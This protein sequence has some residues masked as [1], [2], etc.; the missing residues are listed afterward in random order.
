MSEE[1]TIAPAQRQRCF[2]D[3]SI[4]GLQS[5]RIVFELHNDIVPRTCENFRALCTGEKG[6]GET[7]KKPLY[8]KVG[9]FN[10]ANLNDDF[11]WFVFRA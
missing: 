10:F 2:F 8:Y 9:M 1:T 7:T 5:G 3:L 6:L 4:G 11:C